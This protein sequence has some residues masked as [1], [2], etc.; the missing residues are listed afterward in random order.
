MRKMEYM[1]WGVIYM[2]KN[3]QLMKKFITLLLSIFLIPISCFANEYKI[4]N[5]LDYKNEIENKIQKECPKIQKQIDKDFSKAQKVYKKYLK[6]KEN[7]YVFILQDYQRGIEAYKTEL[8]SD[9]I[10]ITDKYYDIKN[11]IPATDYAGTLFEFL[12]PYFEA[13]NIDYKKYN[14]LSECSARKNSE[15]EGYLYII[16]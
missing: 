12:Y 15:I 2:V 8:L 3:N 10:E 7:E 16:Q 13:N 9:L 5:N 4:Q 1:D 11:K 14:E 6:N